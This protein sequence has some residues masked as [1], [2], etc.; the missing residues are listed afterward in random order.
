MASLISRRSWHIAEIITSTSCAREMPQSGKNDPLS[1]H[2]AVGCQD[3]KKNC[4]GE[5]CDHRKLNADWQISKDI[6]GCWLAQRAKKLVARRGQR[7]YMR[8]ISV[9]IYQFE[10]CIY[11]FPLQRA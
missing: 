11:D 4:K 1:R 9:A 8:R 7:P 6:P 10:R 2:C 3:A 5:H